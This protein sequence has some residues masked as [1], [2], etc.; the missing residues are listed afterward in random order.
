MPVTRTFQ[1]TA[2]GATQRG[3]EGR[4]VSSRM[5]TATRT[6][7][8]LNGHAVWHP[9]GNRRAQGFSLIETLVVIGIISI[10][11]SLVVASGVY[12]NGRA[13]QSQ[14]RGILAALAAI[15]TEYRAQLGK[16]VNHI[17]TDPVDWT[18]AYEITDPVGRRAFRVT[19]P[20]PNTDPMT[21]RVVSG[22]HLEIKRF[23]VAAK[24]NSATAAMIDNLINNTKN[25]EVA[26]PDSVT[27]WTSY[28]TNTNPS[29]SG[30]AQIVD[31][32]G[33][34]IDYRTQEGTGGTYSAHNMPF[35]VSAGSD[36]KLGSVSSTDSVVQASAKDNLYSYDLE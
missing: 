19:Y 22:S 11:V 6:H 35:F 14:T 17:G 16:A 36:G 15:D 25:V 18:A 31:G 26:D 7:N 10:L 21:T 9:T 20:D 28:N 2:T 29:Y 23:I 13:K 34:P 32:W 24:Q 1:T 3:R 8:S 27:N 12:L 33:N 4:C 30:F 5:S